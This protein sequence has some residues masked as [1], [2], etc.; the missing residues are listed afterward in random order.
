MTEITDELVIRGNHIK[1]RIVMPPMVTFSFHGDNGSYYGKQHIEHYTRRAKGGAGLIIVQATSVFGAVDS[2]DTWTIG[3]IGA[4]KQ[5][6]ANCHEHGAIIMMQLHCGN[7]NINEL[8][9][10]EIHSMQKNMR[11]A[12]IRACEIGFNGVEYHFAHGFTLC[13][14]L[15]ASYNRRTD[16]YGGDALY[17][18]RILTQI[19]PEIR[20][21]TH[22]NFIVSVR[23]GEYLPESKDGIEAAKAFEKAGIDLLHISFG[24]QPP[25]NPVPDGFICS[26]ITYSGCKIKKEVNIPVIAVNEIRT[27]EQV[28]FLIENDYVD[29][30][31]VG[32]GMLTDPDFANHVINSEPVNMCLGCERCFWFSDHTLCPARSNE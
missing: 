32:R 21:N 17:R 2:T 13:K 10:E 26:S 3:D 29:L 4:L 28:R 16:K 18:A 15:D 31:A 19:L 24:M 5:I 11:Q 30:V 22:K 8:S 27:E 14:F 1:N 9:A 12:A 6:A 20:N 7:L 25:T 23:M